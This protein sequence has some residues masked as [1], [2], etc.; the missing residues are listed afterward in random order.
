MKFVI[1]GLDE[2]VK[3][4]IRNILYICFDG[5]LRLLYFFMFFIIEEFY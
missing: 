3:K 5:G 1:Y 2:E 4:V